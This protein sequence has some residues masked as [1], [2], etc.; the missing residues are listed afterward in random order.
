[1]QISDPVICDISGLFGYPLPYPMGIW[2]SSASNLKK[3]TVCPD[4]EMVFDN[5]SCNI[6]LESGD[7]GK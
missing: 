6:G 2:N 4:L 5:I 3:A 7:I 1:M